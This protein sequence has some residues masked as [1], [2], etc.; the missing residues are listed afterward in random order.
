METQFSTVT[1]NSHQMH[2]IV[3]LKQ[4]WWFSS[5]IRVLCKC[6]TTSISVYTSCVSMMKCVCKNMG[7]GNFTMIM[8]LAIQYNFCG[9]SL[10][11]KIFCKWLCLPYS[12]CSVLWHS[13]FLKLKN[14][15]TSNLHYARKTMMR[16]SRCKFWKDSFRGASNTSRNGGTYVCD[17]EDNACQQ[18]HISQI[19]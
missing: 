8:H 14:M 7:T 15:L 13:L 11:F 12:L 17:E 2:R 6:V 10:L 19:Q 5:M 3:K 18:S 9:Y 1:A 16:W 4:R